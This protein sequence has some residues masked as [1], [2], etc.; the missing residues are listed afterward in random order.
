[1]FGSCAMI[2]FEG[3][4]LL[5]PLT[6][7]NRWA[8]FFVFTYELDCRQFLLEFFKIRNNVVFIISCIVPVTN[9]VF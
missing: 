7:A 5:V 3:S 2:L 1:M 6:C 9:V 4:R 8:G